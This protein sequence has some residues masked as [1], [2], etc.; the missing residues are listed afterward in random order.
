MIL[1]GLM[2]TLFVASQFT[3][4]EAHTPGPMTLE[5]DMDTD[6][7][8]VTVVHVTADVNT[9]Y[10]Y[11]IVVQKNSVQVDIATY[12]SQSDSSQVIETFTVPAEEG[13]VLTV[14]AKCSVSGQK[15]EEL[16]VGSTSTNTSTDGASDS[17]ILMILVAAAIVAI[18]VVLVIVLVVK[19]R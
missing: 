13:D 9:H 14:T 17:I 2:F 3:V 15:T 8:T 10:I 11:E 12:T 16:T 5:Y 1:L 4:A 19:R 6:V 18:G 7:L